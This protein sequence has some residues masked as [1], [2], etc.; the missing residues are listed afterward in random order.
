MAGTAHTR[1]YFT[2]FAKTDVYPSHRQRVS[3]RLG[4]DIGGD[5][6][7]QQIYP[8]DSEIVITMF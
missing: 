1:S 3:F 4:P 6:G 8:T 5:I 7:G 2:H